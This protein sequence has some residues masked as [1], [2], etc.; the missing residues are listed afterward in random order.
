VNE[1]E[2]GQRY[3][4]VKHVGFR[5]GAS[6]FRWCGTISI[7]RRILF[8]VVLSF[9]HWAEVAAE[10]YVAKDKGQHQDAVESESERVE[11]H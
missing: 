7:Y 9:L 8:C 10:E 11:E 4:S 2:P 5:F 3:N 1:N 6:A